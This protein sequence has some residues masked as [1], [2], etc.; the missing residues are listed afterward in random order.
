M[1]WV[2][3]RGLLGV[4][5]AQW[6]QPGEESQAEDED[7]FKNTAEDNIDLI[8]FSLKNKGIISKHKSL[9]V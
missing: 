8:N 5:A 4:R 3:L 1:L 6:G 7:R 9:T 2:T